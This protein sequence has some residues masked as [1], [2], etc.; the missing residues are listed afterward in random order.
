MV[1]DI[2]IEKKITWSVRH[3]K[4]RYWVYTPITEILQ[5]FIAPNIQNMKIEYE[6]N[7]DNYLSL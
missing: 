1:R 3:I 4:C 7:K 5:L 6:N 2:Q